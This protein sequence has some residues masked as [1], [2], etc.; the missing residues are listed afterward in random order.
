[1]SC[2]ERAGSPGSTTLRARWNVHKI[3]TEKKFSFFLILKDRSTESEPQQFGLSD[4]ATD[5]SRR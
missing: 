4:P 3:N 1:M 5:M 2:E